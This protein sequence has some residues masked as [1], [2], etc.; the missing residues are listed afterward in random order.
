MARLYVSEYDKNFFGNF[1]LLGGLGK[2]WETFLFIA[3]H[4]KDRK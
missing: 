2:N 4:F 1:M 3:L